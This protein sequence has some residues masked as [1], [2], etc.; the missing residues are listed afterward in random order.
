LS[1]F[2][3]GTMQFGSAVV[4]DWT[5]AE[6]SDARFDLAWTLVVVGTQQSTK[7]RDFILKEYERLRGTC[8]ERL[9]YFEVAACIKRLGFV[10]VALSRG[11]EELGMRAD[12]V[13]GRSVSS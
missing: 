12:A 7:W 5:Q 6:I 13:A 3:L 10:F 4:I 11:P 9:A 8:V 1:R 2:T